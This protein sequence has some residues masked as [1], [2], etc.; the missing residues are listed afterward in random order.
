MSNQGEHETATAHHS[1]ELGKDNRQ[2]FGYDSVGVKAAG[3]GR[4]SGINAGVKN[5]TQD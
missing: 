2:T 1:T 4:E 3:G 5:F